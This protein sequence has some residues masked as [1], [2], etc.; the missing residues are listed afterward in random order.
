[1]SGIV[2]NSFAGWGGTIGGANDDTHTR[3][4]NA[5][6]QVFK[7]TGSIRTWYKPAGVTM[8]YIE[9]IGAGGGGAGGR[10]G[11]AGVGGSGGGGGALARQLF[12]AES[13]PDTLEVRVAAIGSSGAAGSNGGTGDESYV[14]G[15]IYGQTNKV[16]LYAYGGGGGGRATGDNGAGG[17]GGGT[18]QQGG[19]ANVNSAADGGNPTIGGVDYASDN[20][21]LGGRGA[22]GG[23]S[24]TG[25]PPGCAEYG[26][27]GGAG[28]HI[29]DMQGGGSSIYGAGGGGG[30]FTGGGGSGHGGVWGSYSAG[31]GAEGPE[32]TQ[33]L[34]NGV[35]RGYGCGDGG[36]GQSSNA[37]VGSYSGAAGV[38][39]GGGG[40]GSY[41][42]LSYN[43]AARPGG[44]GEVRIFSW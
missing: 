1:M 20:N 13:L 33:H 43:G 42:N 30:G 22:K 40:G 6:L 34:D 21:T 36:P 38:P 29:N 11:T 12:P 27:G 25:T 31:G 39:G 3:G 15:D 2:K 9:A 28:V 23:P 5:D 41:Y 4:A 44:R 19:T 32:D 17:G 14:R 26:G 7:T 18:A 16:F 10:P 35:A 8:V 24:D 37:G